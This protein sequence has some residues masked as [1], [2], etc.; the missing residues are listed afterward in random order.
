MVLRDV[1]GPHD[2]DAAASTEWPAGED[3]SANL[4]DR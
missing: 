4:T 1:N 3:L 2:F